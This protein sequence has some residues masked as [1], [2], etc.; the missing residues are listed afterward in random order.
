VRNLE[1]IVDKKRDEL[2]EATKKKKAMEI[3][4]TRHLEK[5]QA[6]ERILERMA[7]DEKVIA[8]HNRR[9]QE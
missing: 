6:E 1:K 4:K 2:L 7:I 9:K 5:Y 8:E 3:C